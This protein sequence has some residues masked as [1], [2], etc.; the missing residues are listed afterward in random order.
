MIDLINQCYIK[1][2]YQ[3][4]HLIV[5]LEIVENKFQIG[6]GIWKFNY[7][8]L[9]DKDYLDLINRIIDE[10]IINYAL[11]ISIVNFLK[12][13][14]KNIS[15]TIDDDLF[16]ELLFLRI[17]GETIKFSSFSR[18]KD[19]QIE[20]SLINDINHLENTEIANFQLLSDKKAAFFPQI[21]GQMIRSRIQWLSE[22]EKPSKFFCNLESKNFLEKT[23]KKVKN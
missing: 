13:N 6:K 5:F 14:Y 21:Q 17:R 20:K 22:G 7:S 11:P 4:D 16:L 10:E 19:R 3:S 12:E 1:V 15:F 23:I 2:G 9:K 18:K 8:L